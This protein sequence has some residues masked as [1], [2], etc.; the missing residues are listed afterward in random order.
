M[1]LLKVDINKIMYLKELHKKCQCIFKTSFFEGEDCF[2]KIISSSSNACKVYDKLTE[3]ED[4]KHDC[5]GENFNELILNIEREWFENYT[6]NDESLNYYFF[7]YYL[8]LYLFV[9][10]VELIF[11]IINKDNKSKI[12]SDYYHTNFKE[13]KRIN[14]WANFIKHPKEFLFTHLPIYY[15]KGYYEPVFKEDDIKIDTEFISNHY[16]NKYNE[17][18]YVLENNDKVYV[19]IPDLINTTENFCKEINLFFEFICK[20]QIVA[21]FLKKKSTIESY[22][23]IEED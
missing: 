6:P 12:F 7:N 19:E 8:L 17:R 16:S 11:K 1:G 10:R 20:N 14:N 4:C 15:I 18:P 3:G 23:G 2:T 21:D 13:L 5:I 22:Y 9:E